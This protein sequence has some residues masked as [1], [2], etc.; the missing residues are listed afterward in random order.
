MLLHLLNFLKNPEKIDHG[1]H[2]NMKQYNTVVNI[3]TNKKCLLSIKS[4]Y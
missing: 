2:K 4:A 3:D 1:F